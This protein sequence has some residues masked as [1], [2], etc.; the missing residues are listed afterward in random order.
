MAVTIGPR[1][2][3]V[4]LGGAAAWPVAARAQQPATPVIGFPSSAQPSSGSG[5]VLP[6]AFSFRRSARKKSRGRHRL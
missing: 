4:A 6:S 5:M 3:L 1:E 2:L